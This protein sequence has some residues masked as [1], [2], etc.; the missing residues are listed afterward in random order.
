MRTL[1]LCKGYLS[2]HL[3]TVA[4]D[5]IESIDQISG[6]L[7]RKLPNSKQRFKSV[8]FKGLKNQRVAEQLNFELKQLLYQRIIDPICSCQEANTVW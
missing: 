1:F 4:F 2:K 8:I 7:V 6:N 5:G 3:K